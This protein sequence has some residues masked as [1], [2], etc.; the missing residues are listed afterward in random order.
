VAETDDAS[1]AAARLLESGADWVTFTSASTVNHFQDRFNLPKLL[2]RF[3]QMRLATIGPET[4]KA[5]TTLGLQPAVEANEHTVEGL[6]AALEHA[7][8]NSR[9]QIG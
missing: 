9:V 4:T 3:P 6:V 2:E 1:G 5:L 7:V 8:K